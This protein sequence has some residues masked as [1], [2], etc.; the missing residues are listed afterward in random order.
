MLPNW[1]LEDLQENWDLTGI[2]HV[3][4]G[5]DIDEDEFGDEFTL[6]DGDHFSK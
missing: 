4:L 1:D 5:V 2:Y 3:D 6:P